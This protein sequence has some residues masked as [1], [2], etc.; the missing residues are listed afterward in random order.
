MPYDILGTVAEAVGA[1]MG[2]T[3]S[4]TIKTLLDNVLQAVFDERLFGTDEPDDDEDKD[5]WAALESFFGN[6]AND[7]PILGRAAALAGIGDQTLPTADFSKLGDLADSIKEN[8]LVSGDTLDKALTAGGEFLYGGNQLRKTAQGT[9]AAARGGVYSK[10]KL[11][12]PVDR[13]PWNVG[14]AVL[15]GRGALDETQEYY[16]RQ[17]KQFSEKQTTAWEKL[18]EA[19]GPAKTAQEQRQLAKDGYD[20]I[21]KLRSIEKENEDDNRA[22]MQRQ[23]LREADVSDDVKAVVWYETMASEKDQET[24]DML[25]DADRSKAALAMMDMKDVEKE[26]DEDNCAAMKRQILRKADIGDDAKAVVWYETLAS[27]KDQKAMDALKGAD[28]GEAAR[29]M[30]DMKDSEKA[31]EKLR[32][33]MSSSLTDEQ[34]GI[35]YLNTL[36][37]DEDKEKIEVLEDAYMDAYQYLAYKTA[38]SGLSGRFEKLNAINTLDLT[39]YQKDA[40]YYM[41]GWSEKTHAAAPWV[42]GVS[43]EASSNRLALAVAHRE[44]QPEQTPQW[45]QGLE[46]YLGIYE[47]RRQAL[48]AYHRGQQATSGQGDIYERRRQAMIAYHRGKKG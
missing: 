3:G 9:I 36:A 5:W 45:Q 41:N 4:E 17:A 39:N 12:Y 1:A 27:E 15:F 21:Q 44:S 23:A 46:D 43:A 38:I 6:A 22:A 7:V 48:I 40:L 31:G 13:S 37:G 29:V 26:D 32:I 10:G 19:G 28:K 35:L 47:Q 34:K 20:L 8:G 42:Q 30:M 18:Q 2:L 11:R 33:I 14:K 25:N 24:L 16:A